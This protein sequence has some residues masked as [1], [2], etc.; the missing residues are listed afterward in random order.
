MRPDDGTAAHAPSGT[1]L[2]ST[3]IRTGNP[4]SIGYLPLVTFSSP[5]T[6][7]AGSLYHIV[8]RNVDPSPTVNYVSIDSLYVYGTTLVPRQPGLSDL[9]WGQMMNSGS[10][11]TTRA[12]FTPILDLGYANGV[13]GGMGY[14]EVWVRGYQRISG[15]SLKVRELF[16]VSG[17]DRTVSRVATVSSG[18]SS[19]GR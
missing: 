1:V 6:L 13:H 7:T 14:M 11:W 8:F 10:G 12:N 4:V 18:G 15:A 5:A 2:A 17:A 9:D 3:T 16:T 19:R